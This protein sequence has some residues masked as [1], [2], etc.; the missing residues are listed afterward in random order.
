MNSSLTRRRLMASV[1]L[2]ATGFGVSAAALDAQNASAVQAPG[3]KRA[4]LLHFT[5]T[6]AQLETHQDYLPG[7]RQE[8]QMMGGYARLKT[9]IERERAN[10][11]DACLL[12]DGGD[13]FQGSGPAA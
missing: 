3:G 9:A 13:E 8:I 7:A 5:D 10:C 2:S 6:H 1:G 4:T 12:L 11:K